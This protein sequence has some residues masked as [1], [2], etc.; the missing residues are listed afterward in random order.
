MDSRRS[1]VIPRRK[2][3]KRTLEAQRVLPV[4]AIVLTVIAAV[5]CFDLVLVRVAARQKAATGVHLYEKGLAAQRVGHGPEALELFRSAYNHTPGNPGYALAFA[6]ALYS[7]GHPSEARAVLS[8]LLVRRPAYGDANAEMARIIAESGDWQRAAWYYH[9]AL[10][11]EWEPSKDLRPLRFELADLLARHGAREQLMSEVVLLDIDI[12]RE[13]EINAAE[14]KH[15]GRLQLAA[16]EDQGAERLYRL[17]LQREPDDVELVVGHARAQMQ[18]GKYVA[19]ERELRRAASEGFAD[20]SVKRDLELLTRVNAMDP[21]IRRLEPKEKHRRAHELTSTLLAV[22]QSCA[23][24]DPRVLEVSHEL[25]SHQ[26]QGNYFPLAENDLDLFERM[27][28]RRHDI[29]TGKID[30]P[31]PVELLGAQLTK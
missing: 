8:D 29:C 27:W 18:L 1:T 7:T 23:P 30:L 13:E 12:E 22:L 4:F 28:A 17:L 10:Y 9:R 25:A 19:A 2:G 20:G 5:A 24:R 14:A 31:R 6:N 21:T 16:G 11:G 15:L 3:S 26:R